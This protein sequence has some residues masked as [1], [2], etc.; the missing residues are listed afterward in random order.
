M[1]GPKSGR[2]PHSYVGAV[3][4]HTRSYGGRAQSRRASRGAGSARVMTTSSGTPRRAT[5]S[6]RHLS[7]EDIRGNGTPTER[8]TV[9]DGG[10]TIFDRSGSWKTKRSRSLTDASASTTRAK[11]T[12]APPSDGH[13]ASWATSNDLTVRSPLRIAGETRPHRTGQ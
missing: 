7:C 10:R 2:P 4:N 5:Q 9:T 6:T 3:E 8:A 13:G 11:R 1:V 12:S